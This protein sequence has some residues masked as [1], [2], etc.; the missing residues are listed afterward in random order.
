MFSQK[1]FS[2][3]NS[4]FA[5]LIV[6]SVLLVGSLATTPVSVHSADDA[7]LE[8]M[9]LEMTR[10][11]SGLKTEETPPYFLSYGVTETSS[12]AIVASFGA[13]T[14]DNSTKN[15]VLDVDL[16]V[17]SYKLDNTRPIRGVAFELGRGTRGVSMPMGDDVDA[18]RTII[19]RATDK[20]F[21]LRPFAVA[22]V[23]LEQVFAVEAAGTLGGVTFKIAASD[24]AAEGPEA[25]PAVLVLPR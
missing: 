25:V 10:T 4:T 23:W 20:A 21:R 24:A 3:R 13:I 22:G 16:R 5:G 9:Q 18:L 15:R 14:L 11:M 17:G 6:S 2:L 8:A 1:R 12:T 7:V 19:W